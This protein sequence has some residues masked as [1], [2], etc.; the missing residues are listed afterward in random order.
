[1]ASF[2][3]ENPAPLIPEKVTAEE[4]NKADGN[5]L[6]GRN[7]IF[8]AHAREAH[9]KKNFLKKSFLFVFIFKNISDQRTSKIHDHTFTAARPVSVVSKPRT[10][11]A[12]I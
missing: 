2:E 12:V 5:N 3:D 7:S 11:L 9:P 6:F 10:M 8:P 4:A 1:M